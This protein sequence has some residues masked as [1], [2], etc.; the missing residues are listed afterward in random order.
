MI[1]RDGD[2]DDDMDDYAPEEMNDTP[3]P[4]PGFQLDGVPPEAS[5]TG[6]VDNLQAEVERYKDAQDQEREAE[7][8]ERAADKGMEYQGVPQEPTYHPRGGR[9]RIRY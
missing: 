8:R 7:R 2:E 1:S 9:G 6:D 3:E 5:T 4:I